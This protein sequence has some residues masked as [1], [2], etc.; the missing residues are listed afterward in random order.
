M[1]GLFLAILTFIPILLYF[2]NA[3]WEAKRNKTNIPGPESLP[4]LGH[5]HLFWKP[6]KE[7]KSWK[8][9]MQ[10]L[11]K[12]GDTISFR[13]F[14][15]L[16]ICTKDVK[17]MEII[18]NSPK[19]IKSDEY[20]FFRVWLGNSLVITHGERWQKLRKLLT[21]AFHF[22][23]LERFV[24]I[25]DEQSEVLIKKIDKIGETEDAFELFHAFALDVISES[26][27]GI[28][29]N[30]QNDPKSK[31]VEANTNM[32]LTS[33]KRMIN[34]LWRNEWL[35][36]LSSVY[37]SQ[38]ETISYIDK[39][40]NDLIEK[41]RSEI[42]AKKVED[43]TENKK[44]KPA[45]LDILL[46]SEMD[47]K[48]LTNEDIRGEVNTFMF[49]GHETTG[50]TLAFTFFLL[51]KHPE[52]QQELYE[53]IKNNFNQNEP[54]TM[55]ALNSLPLLDGVIKEALRIHPIFPA[56]P[57]K[58]VED[59][60]YNGMTIP[61]QTMILTFFLP[62][63]MDEKYFPDPKKFM[64]SRWLDEVTA[65]ERN[66]Y[67]YQPFSSGLRNCIGQKFAMLEAKT[68]IIKIL[69]KYKVELGVEG[70][71]PDLVVAFSVKT[72]NG[73]PLKFVRRT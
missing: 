33:Y 24:Q 66:P 48:P 65:K 8:L 28:K 53:E 49:A 26:A 18:A 13:I 21:P 19:F 6:G 67:A 60:H 12:Y 62:N 73:M 22:Q 72:T 43:G 41:R 5:L 25:F 27:M 40:V 61:K 69:T 47:G 57:K 50:S 52:I 20:E 32:L 64:P 16:T 34:P 11:E 56:I 3:R 30:A 31:F 38:M 29:I 35:W 23:I 9:I 59:V 1:L 37:T 39:F 42:L 4:I 14:G 46:Q 63:H 55:R 45:L 17:L 15:R 2:V 36:K 44:E 68:A 58:C 70:F 71:E 51:A 54:L 10:F 7:R